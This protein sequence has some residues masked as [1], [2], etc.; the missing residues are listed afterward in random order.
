[1]ILS[2]LFSARQG[3]AEKEPLLADPVAAP[4]GDHPEIP[5]TGQRPLHPVQ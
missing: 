2:S 1:M 4:D 5:W 3:K